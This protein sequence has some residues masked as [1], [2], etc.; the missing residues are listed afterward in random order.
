MHH[1]PEEH[2]AAAISEM[3]RILRPSGRLLLA[4]AHPTRWMRFLFGRTARR[5]SDGDPF[6]AIDIRRY[7]PLLHSVGF[8]EIEHVA[9]KYMTGMTMASKPGR[10]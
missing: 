4:D 9:G 10:P 3:W 8:T 5:H 2:R 1:I 6:D 7:T